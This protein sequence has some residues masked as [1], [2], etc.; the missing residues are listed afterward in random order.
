M[1]SRWKSKAPP[2]ALNGR[3]PKRVEDDEIGVGEAPCDLTRF[4]LVLFLLKGVDEFG[5][6]EEPDAVAVMLDRLD[7]DRRGE[8]RFAGSRT[9]DQDGVVG[10]LQELAAVKLADERLVDLACQAKSKPARSR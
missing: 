9:A 3:E 10:V 7:A 5:G 4:L 1:L 6:G 2:E 8:M